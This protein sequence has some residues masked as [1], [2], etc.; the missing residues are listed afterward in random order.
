MSRGR[1]LL[2]IPVV[3]L[4][5]AAGTAVAGDGKPST[6]EVV[7]EFDDAGAILKGNDVRVDGI[8]AGIVRKVELV[9]NKAHLTLKLDG[10]F[11]PIHEDATVAI[12]PISLLGE[13][14]VDLDRGTAVAPVLP[15]GGLIPAGQTRRSV[16]LDEVLSAVDQPTGEALSALLVGL[17]GGMAGRG[18]DAAKA[19]EAL[20]PALTDTASLL[21]LLSDQNT[22]L[23]EL[24]DRAQPALSA[25]GADRGAR[26]DKLVGSTKGLLDTTAA[27]A[28]HLGATLKRLPTALAT[29]RSALMELAALAGET[30]P[31]LASLRPL[32]GD[33][34]GFAADLSEFASVAGPALA[35]LDPVLAKG[36]E[37]I[38]A[39]HPV[40]ADLEAAGGDARAVAKA[41][42]SISDALPADLANLFDFVRNFALATSGSDGI[43][44]YL[45]FLPPGNQEDVDGRSPFEPPQ[46]PIFGRPESTDRP[47][48]PAAPAPKV[49]GDP[50]SAT[51]LTADQER[52][53]LEYLVGG[54][55]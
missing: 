34:M 36:R 22:L 31:V 16:D 8:H 49:N 27:A 51:G 39:A 46:A 20:A 17:G 29:A 54:G 43:S 12:R 19:I 44:H 2:A 15:D 28:P 18:E 21:A 4:L 24:I 33:L 14:F 45:R 55:K 23:A 42:R 35:S 50:G 48:V 53:L 11:A 25:L 9:N 37:L 6:I 30:T 40:I 1:A 10:D 52:S 47:S 13:R 7:A 5:A 26:L 38:E 32:T 41:G 3:M